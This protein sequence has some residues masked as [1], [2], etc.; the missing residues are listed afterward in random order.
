MSAAAEPA[1]RPD[2]FAW[3]PL[4]PYGVA[5]F[6]RASVARLL[7]FQL[8]AALLAAGAIT[9]FF[10]DS[11]FPVV[12]TAI[13]QLPDTSSIRA[14]RLDWPEAAPRLLAPGRILALDVDP[15]HSRQITTSADVQIEF[16]ASTLRLY[17][18]LGY[19]EFPY[20]PGDI[21]S[22]NRPG[23]G[24][25]WGAWRMEILFLLPLASVIGLL[26]SWWLL[27]TVYFIPVWLLGVYTNRALNLRQA[28]RLCGAALLPGALL[29]T[30]GILLYDLGGLNLVQFSTVFIAH[31]VLTWIYL[32][33]SLLFLPRVPVAPPKG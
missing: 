18:L 32:F 27:A 1:A 26:S 9:W 30:L 13:Q 7:L 21:I 2:P 33:V 28:W 3:E 29:L 6:A 15:G 16:G 25:L 31:L 23:L 24:P 20:P 10:Y 5:A 17:S 11:I 4:T 19:L 8:L 12:Q 22:F 14:G